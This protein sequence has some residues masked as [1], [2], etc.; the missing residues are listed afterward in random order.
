MHAKQ[1]V[2]RTIIFTFCSHTG[3]HIRVLHS[4]GRSEKTTRRDQHACKTTRGANYYFHHTGRRCLARKRCST[5]RPTVLDVTVP[6]RT[7]AKPAM[8]PPKSSSRYV[9][10]IDGQSADSSQSSCIRCS[11]GLALQPCAATA[12]RATICMQNFLLCS[13]IAAWWNLSRDKLA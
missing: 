2:E 4:S 11:L 3:R 6:P 5:L 9:Q 13:F 12:S 8:E 7:L 1:H 10:L